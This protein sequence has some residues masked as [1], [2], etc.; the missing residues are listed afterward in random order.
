MIG[1]SGLQLTVK[2]LVVPAFGLL[3]AHHVGRQV[4]DL[5]PGK[6]LPEVFTGHP[7]EESLSLLQLLTVLQHRTK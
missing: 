3:A 6:L 7:A 5:K 2:L 1:A 4:A